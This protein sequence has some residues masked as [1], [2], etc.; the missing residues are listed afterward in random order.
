[1]EFAVVWHADRLFGF[2]D[3]MHKI[4]VFHVVFLMR[5]D[6]LL[7]FSLSLHIS[8]L[9][10]FLP[11]QFFL[12]FLFLFF[13][14]LHFHPLDQLEIFLILLQPFVHRMLQILQSSHQFNSLFDI[15]LV[16]VFDSGELDI[17]VRNGDVT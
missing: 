5:V 2:V 8:N 12:S 7:G 1:V 11:E 13:T 15:A 14:I 16:D 17:V 10:L 6:D 4:C 9:C 3:E